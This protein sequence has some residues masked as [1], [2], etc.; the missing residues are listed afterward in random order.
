MR[1]SGTIEI[2]GTKTLV[3]AGTNPDDLGEP[4][5]VATTTPRET[6]GAVVEHLRGL[7]LASVGVASFGPVELRPDHPDYGHI[8]STPKPGWQST[9]VVSFFEREL[10]V[11]VGFD[12]DVNGAA[13][14]EGGWGAA[15]GLSQFVYITVG[16]GIGGGAV[17]GGAALHGLVHPEMGHLAIQRL[18]GDDFPGL[19]PVHGDCLEGMVSGPALEARFG[20]PGNELRGT[21]LST[22][23]SIVT[24]YLAQGL[25]TVV[26]TLAPQRIIVGGGVAKLPG[27]HETLSEAVAGELANYPG[28]A[29]HR[30]P[31]FVS[32][33]ELGDRSGLVGGLVLAQQAL[34]RHVKTLDG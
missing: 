1:V 12:T 28:L 27:F 2:G 24:S 29:E 5:R 6:L 18:S 31:G 21:A 8:T 20:V 16:T 26:Y 13:L 14:G 9:R 3:A 30:E 19:C 10:G 15:I 17:V 4:A 34:S 25:R 23:L 7:E 32:P 33:P 22:A 11:P